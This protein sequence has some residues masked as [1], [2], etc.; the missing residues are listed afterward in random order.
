MLDMLVL[1]TYSLHNLPN[2][3]GEKAVEVNLV[4]KI[5]IYNLPLKSNIQKEQQMRFQN[6]QASKIVKTRKDYM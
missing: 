3:S 6:T 2:Q 4:V 5:A 1:S